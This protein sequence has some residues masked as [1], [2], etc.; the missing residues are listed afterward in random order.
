MERSRVRVI[1]I[2]LSVIIAIGLWVYV[3]NVVNPPMSVTIR[4]VPIQV[5][6]LESIQSTRLTIA[7]DGVYTCDVTVNGARSDVIGI[8]ADSLNASI[9]LTGLSAG[10]N[11]VTVN[12]T[13]PS[14]ISIEDIRSQKIQVYLDELVTEQKPVNIV[15]A[16]IEGDYEVTITAQETD[17]MLVTGAKSL[18]SMI[19]EI[20]IDLDVNAL[21]VDES[22]TLRIAGVPLDAEGN[23]VQNVKLSRDQI[24]I[25]ASIYQLF[26][27][28]LAI[29]YEGTP[30]LGAQLSKV[31]LPQTLRVKGR[32][33]L[34]KSLGAIPTDVIN[35]EGI[36]DDIVVPVVYRLPENVYLGDETEQPEASFTLIHTGEISFTY[37]RD[38]ILVNNV[39]EDCLEY[40]L[41][42]DFVATVTAK[43]DLGIIRQIEAK[44]LQPFIDLSEIAG[45]EN[46]VELQTNYKNARITV[47]IRPSGV[48]VTA[49]MEEEE[50]PPEPAEGQEPSS[51][52][53]PKGSTAKP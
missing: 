49:V 1:D 39:P 4:D 40:S 52:T 48:K 24:Y 38:E 18:V 6:G 47:R 41:P 5:L 35:I 15:H 13:G 14:S 12:V 45:G 7:G 3:I 10:Q 27:V 50:L 17:N 44:D 23:T 29:T 30:G 22:T 31:D 20:R 19:E 26:D 21:K 53:P 51:E 8:D 46:T 34:I 2:I 36:T 33:S 11:Y 9:N 16:D 32:S 43:G 28:P 42:E 37:G 25:T